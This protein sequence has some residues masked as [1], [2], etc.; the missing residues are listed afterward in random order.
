MSRRAA[1]FFAIALGLLAVAFRARGDTA[2]AAQGWRQTLSAESIRAALRTVPP[3]VLVVAAGEPSASRDEAAEALSIALREA[4]ATSVEPAPDAA[5]SPA[6]DDAAILAI[7]RPAA[8]P[9]ADAGAVA[10]VR[11]FPSAAA[12][13]ESLLVVVYGPSGAPLGALAGSRG[14]PATN[15]G[16]GTPIVVAPDAEAARGRRELALAARHSEAQYALVVGNP[17]GE[18]ATSMRI[19][20][21]LAKRRLEGAHFYEEIG[22][23]DL[24]ARYRAMDRNQSLVIVGGIGLAIAGTAV[25]FFG[26]FRPD[27]YEFGC[28][29]YGANGTCDL[30]A[31]HDRADRLLPGIAG[32]VMLNAGIAGIVTGSAWRRDPVSS[33]ALHRLIDERNGLIRRRYEP[34]SESNPTSPAPNGGGSAS[35]AESP[36]ARSSRVTFDL[37]PS[38][39]ANGGGLSLVGTF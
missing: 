27:E 14:A 25:A 15:V 10:I 26:V 28:D 13:P 24:A 17:E 9:S 38:F 18:R 35:R 33:E 19:S 4:G 20:V 32:L 21:G 37:A 22:R 36:A 5:S 16:Q 2:A 11:V 7:V 3:N 31:V 29:R 39:H 34:I 30:L 23:A 8:S 1:P 12:T 6:L